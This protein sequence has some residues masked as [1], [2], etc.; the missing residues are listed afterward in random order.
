MTAPLEP[1]RGRAS[2][3]IQR[4][5]LRAR[6]NLFA[7]LPLLEVVLAERPAEGRLFGSVTGVIQIEARGS[8]HAAHLAFC[9]GRL[10]VVP[11]LH[12]APDVR[13]T[14]RD[15]AAMNAF[16]AG[17][18]ELP[19]IE[20]LRHPVLIAR[21]GAL[22]SSLRILAPGATHADAA[23]RALH[24]RLVIELAPR[25][26]AELCRGGHPETAHLVAESPDRVYQWSVDRTT[27]ASFLR[28]REGRVRWGRGTYAARPPFVRFLFPSVEAA[29]RVLTGTGAEVDAVARGDVATE[30]SPE[31]SRKVSRLLQRTDQL[32]AGE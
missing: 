15:V 28:M 30:G 32:L 20:G 2:L 4:E 18:A 31:Y 12:P 7:L 19:R 23:E 1:G 14:F 3:P 13:C 9:A 27:I 22:L 17:R 25:A 16:F 26:L 10:S 6:V 29:Y 24:V 11:R 8:E 5:A 21:A